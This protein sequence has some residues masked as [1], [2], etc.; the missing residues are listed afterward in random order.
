MTDGDGKQQVREDGF[1]AVIGISSGRNESGP[2]WTT[3]MVSLEST[4][5]PLIA[6]I[7]QALG[8]GCGQNGC[9]RYTGTAVDAAAAAGFAVPVCGAAG[10]ACGAA[11]RAAP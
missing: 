5:T 9:T 3:Q 10:L 1:A 7:T 2:R 11:P 8:N 4:A 6:P